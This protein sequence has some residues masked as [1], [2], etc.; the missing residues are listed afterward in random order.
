[1]PGKGIPQIETDRFLLRGPEPEDYP[2]F[3]VMFGSRHSR[4]MGGPLSD[5]DTWMLYAAEIGHWRIR[6]YGMWTIADKEDGKSLG[7]TGAWFPGGYP[8]PEI[9]WMIWPAAE[10][11]RVAM[12]ATLAARRYL[13]EQ[14]GLDR[15]VSYLD[16]KNYK[17][18]GLAERIGCTKDHD[19]AIVD[20]HEQAYRHPAREDLDAVDEKA[21]AL[22]KE[23]LG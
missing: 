9:A 15:A 21:Y 18:T 3:K 6:G 7:M 20:S 19:A 10:G 4:F 22:L 8:E 13:Y 12:E 2:Q 16:P 5:Y 1:M 17:S 14:H 23:R 11:R